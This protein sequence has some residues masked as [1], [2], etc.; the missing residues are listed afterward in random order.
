MQ[1]IQSILM[2]TQEI[3]KFIYIDVWTTHDLN[4]IRYTII[5]RR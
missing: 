2:Q 5:V 3:T 1:R 4:P